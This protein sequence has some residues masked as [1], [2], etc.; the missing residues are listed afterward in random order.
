MI[1]LF[2][3]LSLFVLLAAPIR[4]AEPHETDIQGSVAVEVLDV[5]ANAQ[6][7][8]CGNSSKAAGAAVLGGTDVIGQAA[9]FAA[10]GATQSRSTGCLSVAC[11]KSASIGS[12]CD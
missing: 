10:F 2:F 4:G 5:L 8:G 7:S 1:K 6:S 9:A 12:G 3:V 11:A